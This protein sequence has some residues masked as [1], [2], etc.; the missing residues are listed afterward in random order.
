MEKQTEAKLIQLHR[1]FLISLLNTGLGFSPESRC[2]IS[3][4]NIE[5]G[6]KNPHHPGMIWQMAFSSNVTIYPLPPVQARGVGN[7][8]PSISYGSTGECD[9]GH[10]AAY[11]KTKHALL[12][13]DN[14]EQVMALASDAVMK[15]RNL[16]NTPQTTD[17]DE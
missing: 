15:F 9:P 6:V 12:I 3:Q 13:L 7:F 4:N 17:E 16:V 5:L 2:V 1:E 8:S 11:W 10:G 14:W